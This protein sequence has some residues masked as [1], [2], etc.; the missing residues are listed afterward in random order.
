MRQGTEV[1]RRRQSEETF[2]EGLKGKGDPQVAPAALLS[3]C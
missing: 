1:T 2:I 3:G